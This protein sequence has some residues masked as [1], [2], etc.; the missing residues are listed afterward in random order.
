MKKGSAAFGQNHLIH[1]GFKQLLPKLL[2]QILQMIGYGWLL[3]P[4]RIGYRSDFLM[5][6]QQLHNLLKLINKKVNIRLT[7]S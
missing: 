7:F 3:Q 6:I 4:E 2:L 1:S 5:L